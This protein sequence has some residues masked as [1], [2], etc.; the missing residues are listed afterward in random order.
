MFGINKLKMEK[1]RLEQENA[2][3]REV[4]DRSNQAN[5]EMDLSIKRLNT[6]NK[7]LISRIEFLER[8]LKIS[9]SENRASQ[10][11]DDSKYY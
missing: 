3:L 9:T 2:Q 11:S 4:L 10:Y 5:K 7:Q 1:Q 8:E 6:L